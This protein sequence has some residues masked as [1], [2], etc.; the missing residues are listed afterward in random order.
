[1]IIFFFKSTMQNNNV[2]WCVRWCTH[3]LN[4]EAIALANCYVN[5]T[6]FHNGYSINLADYIYSMT[7][8]YYQPSYQMYVLEN[9]YIY[10][11]I[12]L[13]IRFFGK[14]TLIQLAPEVVPLVYPVTGAQPRPAS[15][16]PTVPAASGDAA[17]ISNQNILLSEAASSHGNNESAAQSLISPGTKSK[18]TT[19]KYN[20]DSSLFYS[21][22]GSFVP[23]SEIPSPAY[24]DLSS[25][26]DAQIDY[27]L[28]LAGQ[29]IAQP[30]VSHVKSG[31]SRYALFG[32][33]HDKASSKYPEIKKFT[34]QFHY[35]KFTYIRGVKKRDTYEAEKENSCVTSA[36]CKF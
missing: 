20:L 22:D 21:S 36:G 4:P 2:S 1:M 15:V 33:K 27:C 8:M 9:G 11:T 5:G 13:L 12:E 6:E 32:R 23:A 31:K 34:G 19:V 10:C 14:P 7:N 25:S 28:K 35:T 17:V 29:A 24:S 26:P 18:E 30:S 16:L 3:D